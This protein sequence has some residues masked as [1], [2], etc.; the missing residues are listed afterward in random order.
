MSSSDLRRHCT[1]VV[2]RHT[3][4]QNTHTH[5]TFLKIKILKSKPN[6]I[7]SHPTAAGLWGH[8]VSCVSVSSSV[9]HSETTHYR[10][11][12][13]TKRI[14][15]LQYL[16]VYSAVTLSKRKI[17]KALTSLPGVTLSSLT[18]RI[19]K[20]TH[21]HTVPCWESSQSKAFQRPW[22]NHKRN[23]V[24]CP[25]QGADLAWSSLELGPGP[26]MSQGFGSWE[27][28]FSLWRNWSYQ[29]QGCCVVSLWCAMIPCI[30]FVH[31]CL[32]SILLTWSHFSPLETAHKTRQISVFSVFIS[33]P[34]PPQDL[35]LKNNLLTQV[36]FKCFGHL[37]TLNLH[38]RKL[39][40]KG[41]VE[42]I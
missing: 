4:K 17:N 38:Q 28:G 18:K 24:F 22:W 31:Y 14:A 8:F 34:C 7:A 5:K 11:A 20:Y 10:T 6:I 36:C 42:E 35:S 12:W 37:L 30:F 27:L 9:K 15:A 1:H 40:H 21:T 19:L 23:L 33:W 3:Y 39:A 29:S 16:P 26:W 2:L 13:K 25:Y 41:K 32:I